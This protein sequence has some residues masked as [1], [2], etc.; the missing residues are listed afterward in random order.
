MHD[1]KQT[2][3]WLRAIRLRIIVLRANQDD[4]G[5]KC[6][7]WRNTGGHSTAQRQLSEEDLRKR[8][9]WYGHTVQEPFADPNDHE[10]DLLR[11]RKGSGSSSSRSIGI[12]D[13]SDGWSSKKC[14]VS[15]LGAIGGDSFGSG[16]F[17]RCG[18]ASICVL[19][20]GGA[21]TGTGR[22]EYGVAF[23]QPAA[24]ARSRGPSCARSRGRG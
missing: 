20:G 15:C 11:R 13:A 8:L 12:V 16:T 14:L 9:K 2:I 6:T 4:A 22:S 17:T 5:S 24:A 23:P 7:S 3:T 1:A 18:G 19:G 21:L 10:S